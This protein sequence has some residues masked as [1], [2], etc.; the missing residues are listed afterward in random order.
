[1]AARDSFHGTRGPRLPSVLRVAAALMLMPHGAQKLFGSPAGPPP[2]HPPGTCEYKTIALRHVY[3]YTMDRMQRLSFSYDLKRL[4]AAMRPKRGYEVAA[5]PG[6]NG[7]RISRM[8]DGVKYNIIFEGGDPLSFTVASGR[9][10][11]A[12]PDRLI[13]RRAYRMIGDLPLEARQKA[14]LEGH[15]VVNHWAYFSDAFTHPPA[16]PNPPG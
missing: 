8:F 1:M 4:A 11:C 12:T 14:E 15:V 5:L 2:R 9:E 16:D 13:K 6:G 10:R 7:V 3:A